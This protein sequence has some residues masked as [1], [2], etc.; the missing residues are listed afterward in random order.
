MTRISAFF[1]PSL[2][3]FLIMGG[4][5]FAQ[6]TSRGST[7]MA[8]IQVNIE[9]E[10]ADSWEMSGSIDLNQAR[11]RNSELPASPTMTYHNVAEANNTELMRAVETFVQPEVALADFQAQMFGEAVEL[12]WTLVRERPVKALVVE[13][14]QDGTLWQQ[15][16]RWEP[17]GEQHL[18]QATYLDPAPPLGQPN[19]YRLR[20]ILKDGTEAHSEY[21]VVE[22]FGQGWHVLHHFP[23]PIIFGTSIDLALFEPA[24]VTIELQDE[25]GAVV[26]SVYAE[27]TSIGDH[28]F[29][30]DLERLAA[31]N[32][33]CLIKVGEHV[34]RREIQKR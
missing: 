25:A 6:E 13:R 30:L 14:S 2:L 15:I 33:V 1:L 3:V 7:E 26:G 12:N 9:T 32:Y 31:G 17:L 11:W 28:S 4:P 20:Q 5:G 19:Y 8:A 22:N 16:G 34:A 29:E 18:H 23:T 24:P 10:L 27:A 21:L